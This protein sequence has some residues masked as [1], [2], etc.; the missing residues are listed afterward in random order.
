MIST[1]IFLSELRPQLTLTL[2]GPGV[3]DVATKSVDWKR[4]C[5]ANALMAPSFSYV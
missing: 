4:T 1:C 2:V 5:T 3:L